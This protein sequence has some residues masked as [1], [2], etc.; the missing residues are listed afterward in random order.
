MSKPLRL[1]SKDGIATITLA[2]PERMNALAMDM[3][4]ALVEALDTVGQGDDRV[5]I[6]AAEGPA[7]CAG[8]DRAE[9]ILRPP[10]EWEPIVA[11]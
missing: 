5:L 8:A 10:V 11:K 7:F 4:N 3:L 1:E 2:R 6:L 9:M